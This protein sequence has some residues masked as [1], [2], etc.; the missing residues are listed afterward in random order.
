MDTS[1]HPEAEGPDALGASEKVSLA[2][3]VAESIAKITGRARRVGRSVLNIFPDNNPSLA[4]F[5][6]GQGGF[7]EITRFA[8]RTDPYRR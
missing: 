6:D 1:N 7:D 2:R 3:R 5:P 8:D 4:A